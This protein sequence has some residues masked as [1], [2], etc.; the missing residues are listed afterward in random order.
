[1]STTEQHKQDLVKVVTN[2]HLTN[3]YFVTLTHKKPV[4]M[5]TQMKNLRR[6]Q[7][8]L[9]TY[10]KS[11]IASLSGSDK[12]LTQTHSHLILLSEKELN[13]DLMVKRWNWGKV[14]V[15]KV[16][17]TDDDIRLASFYTLNHPHTDWFADFC[18]NPAKC[19]DPLCSWRKKARQD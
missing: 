13:H 17:N 1:M 19:N 18:P 15:T 12:T 2:Y 7:L 3:R 4:S 9:S 6:F 14:E 10:S 16:K 8:R 5:E 11:H